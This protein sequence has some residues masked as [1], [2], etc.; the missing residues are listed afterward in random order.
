MDTIFLTGELAVAFLCLS[1]RYQ[2]QRYSLQCARYHNACAALL[3]KAR[4]RG[5]QLRW[6]VDMVMGDTE[7][8]ATDRLKCFEKFEA[9]ARN[10]GADY[11]GEAKVFKVSDAEVDGGGVEPVVLGGYAYDLGPE[12]CAALKA[13]LQGADLVVV[14]GT[15]GVCESG[16][17]QAGQQC[18]VECAAPKPPPEPTAVPAKPAA[19]TK[20]A[21]ASSATPAVPAPTQNPLR[22]V[23]VGD[24]TVEWF[25]RIVDPDGELEG[26]LVGA[27]R[28][29]YATRE[30]SVFT[31]LMGLL[32]SRLVQGCLSA[33][34]PQQGEF[35]Y[36]Q[37]KPPAEDDDEDEEDDDEDDD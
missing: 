18:L 10:E 20:G 33:R 2:F 4:M 25:T 6:P 1:K 31:G 30:S 7:V 35:V 32:P 21:A 16:S 27:G 37:P 17:F 19:N 28:V 3:A 29:S 8:T 36:S 23:L 24:A 9:D 12:S 5:C 26:D 14:W 13:A 11:E 34:A 15:A 22:T